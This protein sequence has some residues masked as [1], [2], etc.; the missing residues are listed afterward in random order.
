MAVVGVDVTDL[1]AVEYGV[2]PD[3][4]ILPES[5]ELMKK[6]GLV[7][8]DDGETL[9]LTFAHHVDEFVQCPGSSWHFRGHDYNPMDLIDGIRS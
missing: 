4:S 9:A 8:S 2:R 6:R 1:I 7:S 3:D 5:K